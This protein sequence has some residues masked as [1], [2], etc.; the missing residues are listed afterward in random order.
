MKSITILICKLLSFVGKLIGKGSSL[1]GKVALKLCPNILTRLTLPK[2]II[3]I[4]G[5]NGKTS[6]VEMVAGILKAAGKNVVY[7]KE[8]SNQI[9]G[10]TTML[11]NS[12]TLSGKVKG[13]IVLL[14]SD[15]RYARHTFKHI[16]PTMFAI[17]NLYRDQMT[18]NAHPFHIYNIIS[19]AV[20]LIP[21]TQLVLNADDPIVRNFG[22]QRENVVYFGME[23]NGL[24]TAQSDALYNDCHYCPRCKKEMRYDFFHYAH[25]GSYQC[26]CGYSRPKTAYAV[27]EMD[28]D[29]G[30]ITINGSR[31]SL[32]FASK[33]NVYN[34][35]AAYTVTSLLG[36]DKSVIT[37]QLNDFVMKNGR[38]VKFDFAGNEGLLITSKHEN[39]TS[40]NQSLGYVA[41]Q[42][43]KSTLIIIVDAISRKYY[44]S[45]TSWLWDIS[46]EMLQNTN[47]ERIVLSG[48]YAY[49]LALRFEFAGITTAEIIVE[50]D[51]QKMAEKMRELPNGTKFYCVTCFSDK[52]KL[53]RN[54]THE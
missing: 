36:I 34:L 10:V 25:L 33:Y 13:D 28:L 16:K 39:S 6:T 54:C 14:E 45:E 43:E 32:D 19:D 5:S 26:E 27:E 44:T 23:R 40:Y 37:A 18:R 17:T 35:L 20:A 12:A 52:D 24:S 15:E 53:L 49:D 42:K 4:T 48:K 51:L 47:V 38:I 30:Y 3:A 31:L 21:N 46:F 8:G 22:Y 11:L 50:P 7:N 2:D 41:M 29:A 1:P 9:E